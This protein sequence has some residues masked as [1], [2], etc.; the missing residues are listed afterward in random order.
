MREPHTSSNTFACDIAKYGEDTGATVRQS[1]E[2]AGEKAS[3]E[4]F[5]RELQIAHAQHTGSAELALNLG[6]I[7]D[8]RV[9]VSSLPQKGV[10]VLLQRHAGRRYIHGWWEF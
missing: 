6:G 3:R 1:R 4:N 9:Q 2:V 8:L 7:E 5:A 10:H